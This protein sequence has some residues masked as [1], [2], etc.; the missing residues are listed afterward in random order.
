M[1]PAPGPAALAPACTASAVRWAAGSAPAQEPPKLG[2][3]H[4]MLKKRA[5]MMAAQ[6]PGSTTIYKHIDENGRVTYANS[7]IKGGA[8]VDLEPITVIPSTPSGSLGQSPSAAAQPHA[9]LPIPVAP[10]PRE[11][12]APITSVDPSTRSRRTSP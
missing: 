9:P 11:S 2:D 8:R 3:E 10:L 12:Q 7:P 5:E 1:M 6:A 4:E